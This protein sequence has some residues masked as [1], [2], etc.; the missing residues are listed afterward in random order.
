MRNSGERAM[1]KLDLGAVAYGAYAVSAR[2]TEAL[3]LPLWDELRP[4]DQEHWREAADAV[5]GLVAAKIRA[6]G[7]EV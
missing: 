7:H 3:N 6:I 4:A 2:T 1:T 5:V